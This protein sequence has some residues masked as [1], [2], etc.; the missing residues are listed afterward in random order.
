[1]F[2]T[3]HHFLYF[4]FKSVLDEVLRIWSQ[5]NT[6]WLYERLME[7]WLI[8]SLWASSS[9]NGVAFRFYADHFPDEA[10]LLLL[11]SLFLIH[12]AD[13]VIFL[14][15]FQ[16]LS[17]RVKARLLN[18]KCLFRNRVTFLDQIGTR[19]KIQE[20]IALLMLILTLFSNGILLQAVLSINCIGVKP[21]LLSHKI[22]HVP[23]SIMCVYK[24][25]G[26]RLSINVLRHS[27]L[28]KDMWFRV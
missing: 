7:H 19:S 9:C 3:N 17:T 28:H 25:Q 20:I 24:I 15:K 26:L 5:V 4:L 6:Q 11:I 13:P 21:H 14:N 18:M 8:S 10:L 12:F 27:F 16:N 2:R 23:Y 1:M 22:I